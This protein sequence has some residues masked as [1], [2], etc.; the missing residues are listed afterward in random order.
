MKRRPISFI[1][2]INREHTLTFILAY[3]PALSIALILMLFGVLFFMPGWAGV[4]V[5]IIFSLSIAMTIFTVLQK[6][7]NL[8]PEKPTSKINLVRTILFEIIGVLTAMI[9]AG[10]L[11]RYI[12]QFVTQQISNDLTSFAAAIA[13]GLLVGIAA[14]ILMQ[15]AWKRVI[16][17]FTEN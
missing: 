13:T 12:A 3:W 14:G 8:Y 9:L 6:H 17:T 7:K 16:K 5:G 11:A 10:L 4:T 1:L 15:S 2:N